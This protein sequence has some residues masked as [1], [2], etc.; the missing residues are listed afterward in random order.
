MPEVQRLCLMFF[1][2]RSLEQF[3]C[4]GITAAIIIKESLSRASGN[5]PHHYWDVFRLR[6]WMMAGG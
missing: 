1:G 2:S 3:F 5:Y 4:F 6:P